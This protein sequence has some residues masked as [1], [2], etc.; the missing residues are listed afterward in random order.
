M[1]IK[2]GANVY[3]YVVTY[4]PIRLIWRIHENDTEHKKVAKRISYIFHSTME[5]KKYPQ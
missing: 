2:V 3:E 5:L 4:V 1:E